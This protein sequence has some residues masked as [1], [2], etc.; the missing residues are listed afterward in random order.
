LARDD[1]LY[2]DAGRFVRGM[3]WAAAISAPFWSGVLAALI[4]L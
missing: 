2:P 3:A 1:D 4:W